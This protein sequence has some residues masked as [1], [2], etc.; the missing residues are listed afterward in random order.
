MRYSFYYS[1]EKEKISIRLGD[2]LNLDQLKELL[3]G[4]TLWIGSKYGTD[5]FY[6][7]RV[8]EITPNQMRVIMENEGRDE[9]IKFENFDESNYNKLYGPKRYRQSFYAYLFNGVH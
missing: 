3:P 6:P 2:Q 7:A 9:I 4:D 1:R 5:E 8:L